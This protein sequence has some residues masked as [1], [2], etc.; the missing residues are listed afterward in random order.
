MNQYV[1]APTTGIAASVTAASCGLT[2]ARI[3][4]VP[5]IIL[6]DR[7]VPETTLEHPVA[8]RRLQP[9]DIHVFPS[10]SINTPSWIVSPI[11]ESRN[12]SSL[13]VSFERMLMS[14]PV[15]IS[16]GKV[17]VETLHPL[18]ARGPDLVFDPMG[19]EVERGLADEVE[20]RRP[21]HRDRYHGDR[22]PELRRRG[23]GE[24]C[25]RDVQ[26][27]E[28]SGVP[29][30][31]IDRDSEEHRWDQREEPGDGARQHADDE[32]PATATAELDEQPEER[33]LDGLASLFDVLG[34]EGVSELTSGSSRLA[35]AGKTGWESPHA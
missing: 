17:H 10:D 34:V 7:T 8:V 20:Q 35:V 25:R 30:E 12:C 1:N 16:L 9:V 26:Q 14:S 21:D 19:E 11:I 5:R 31:R 29:K 22:E 3:A 32:P 23:L 27:R 4:A 2:H 6:S 24:P 18:V 13:L 15:C 28:R 33:M